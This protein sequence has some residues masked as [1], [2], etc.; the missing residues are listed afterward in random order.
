[1]KFCAKVLVVALAAVFVIGM[2]NNS[3]AKISKVVVNSGTQNYQYDMAKLESS[4]LAYQI[5][6]NS[7]A[8]LLY[9]HYRDKTPVAFYDDI[10]MTYVDFRDVEIA[11]LKSQIEGKTFNPNIYS[12]NEGKLAADTV[13]QNLNDVMVENSEIVLQPVTSETEDVFEV[14]SIE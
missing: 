11:Y 9:L 4:Y 7:P 5:S 6:Q 10:R 8:T 12:E 13:K 2:E 1:M 3:Y 14:I